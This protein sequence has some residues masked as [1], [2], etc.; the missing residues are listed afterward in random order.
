M[1][2]HL[3]SFLRPTQSLSLFFEQRYLLGCDASS[4]GEKFTDVSVELFQLHRI[5]T[6]A[7]LV[8]WLIT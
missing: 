6:T 8:A 4:S 3:C 5:R 1:A 7:L 2:G